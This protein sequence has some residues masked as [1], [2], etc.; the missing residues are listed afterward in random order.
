MVGE[1]EKIPSWA[2]RF[3]DAAGKAAVEDGI[4]GAESRTSGE[5][6][7]A[8]AARSAAVAHLPILLSLVAAIVIADVARMLDASVTVTGVALLFAV[9][10][11][12][13]FARLGWV[14]QMCTAK[15]ER[16]RAVDNA[17][18][19]EFL[20]ARISNTKAATGVLIYVSLMEQRVV[21]LGDS[22]IAAK[23][24]QGQWDGM[25]AAIVKGIKG[26][27]LAGGLKTGVEMAGEILTRHFQVAADDRDELR[28]AVRFLD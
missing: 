22:A 21:V 2:R 8:L 28:N 26:K 15:H 23:M 24:D 1:T 11:C 10:A 7:V 12:F 4:A 18:A 27:D 16:D 3:I 19:A 9:G 20:R 25:V 14:Q 13:F 5:I 6:V 17:A